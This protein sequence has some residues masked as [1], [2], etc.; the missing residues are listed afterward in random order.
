MEAIEKLD[1][2]IFPHLPYSPDLSLCDFHL[3]PEMMEDLEIYVLLG[4][5][6]A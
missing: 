3:F 6:A 4:F 1:L 5:Y 2:T